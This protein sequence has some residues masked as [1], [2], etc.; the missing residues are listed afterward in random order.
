MQY[1]ISAVHRFFLKSAVD[2]S[3]IREYDM[4][5]C[6]SAIRHVIVLVAFVASPLYSQATKFVI[7]G[8]GSQTAGTTQDLTIRADSAGQPA[9]SYTGVKLLTFSGATSS[10]DPVTAPTVKDTGGVAVAFGTSTPITFVN[11]LAQVSAGKNG[12]MTLYRAEGAL[13]SV[14]DGSISSSGAD[15]LTVTVSSG[16]L[17]KFV[18]SLTSPQSNNAGFTGTNTLTAADDWGNPVTTFSAGSNNVTLTVNTLSGMITGLGSGN[19]NILNR[20]ADFS[21][22]VANLST[23][24]IRYVGTIGSGTITAT[25]ASPS[26]NGTSS[27]ITINPGQAQRLVI[28]GSATQTAGQAQNLTVT[29]RDT[30]GNK[31]TGYSGTKNLLF[32]GASSSPDPVTPPTVANASGTAI[33]FGS[34]T[35]ISFVA[36]EATVS[37]G[38]NGRMRLSK[39][40]TAIIAVTDGTISASGTDRLT[41]TVSPDVAGKF[42]LS[43]AASQTNAV[44]FSGTNTITVLDDYGNTVTTFDASV[45]PVTVSPVGLNGTVIV[46]TGRDSV[47]N[48]VG[49]FS[50]GTANLQGKLTYTGIS[51][52]GQFKVTSSTGKTG[53][54]GTVT[55]SPGTAKRLVLSGS[56]AAAAGAAN[57]LTITAQDTSGNTATGYAGA[58]T[59][60]F[61]GAS[62]SPGGNN[63]TVSDNT[64]TARNFSVTPNTQITFTAGVAS[65]SGASNGVMRLYR[66]ESASVSVT[67]GT[68]ST[69]PA[70]RLGVTITPAGLGS[71]TVVMT[72]PQT[73]GLIFTGVNTVTAIDSFGNVATNFNPASNNVTV[74]T[75]LTGT[76]SGL[77]S[78]GNNVLNQ[79][80]DFSN[81]VANVS[82]KMKYTGSVGTGTFTATSQTGKSGTSGSVVINVGSA[83]R[84]VI[85]GSASQVAGAGQSLTITAKDSSGNTVTAYNGDKMLTFSGSG[86]SPN[87]LTYPTVSSKTGVLVNFGAPTQISFSSGVAQVSA[88]NNGVLRL[89]RAGKDTIAASDGSIGSGTN[90]Q[91]IVTVTA[92]ALAKFVLALTSPQQSGIVFTGTN[93]LTAQDNYGNVKTTFDASVDNVTLSANSPLVGVVS[94]LG[95]LSNNVL[96]QAADFALGVATLTGKLKFT[97]TVGSGTF[98]AVSSTSKAGTSE[99][100]QIVAGG[101][102]RLVITGSA[103]MIAGGT[104]ALVITAKDASGNT[105][106]TYTGSKSLTFS[107]ADSALSPATAPTVTSSTG[108]A[109]P[110][111]AVTAITFTNGVATTSGVNNGSMRLLRAQAAIVSV[112]DGSITSSG[113]DRLSVTVGPATLGKFAWVLATPQ[114]N[115]VAFTGTNTLTAQDDWGNTI[116]AFD[117]SATNVAVAT[118]LS[119][120]VSGLGSGNDNILNRSADFVSGVAN[121]TTLGMKYTG[122][123]GTG[124][125][126]ATGGGKTGISTS[127]LVQSGGATRLVVRNAA[128]DSVTTMVAGGSQN[129][130]I[131]AKD[132]SGNTVVTYTG[133]KS[134]IFSGADSSLKPAVAPTVSN[135]TGTAVGFGGATTITF[136]NGVAQVSGSS[137]GILKLYRAQTAL[138]AV[139]D[140]SLS[141]SGNDRLSV[142]VSPA[143]LGKFAWALTSPQT[144]GVGFTGVNTLQAQDDWGNAV[145][146]FNASTSNVTISTSLSG[147]ITGLGSNNNNV[148]NRV[149]DFTGGV[150]NLTAL[151]MTYTGSI[152]NGTFTATAA[153][154]LGT[155]DSVAIV[156]GSA[157]RLVITGTATQVAG[158]AQNLTITARDGSNN[159]VTTYTG[160]KTLTFSGANPAT[161][162]LTP[163]TMTNDSARAV[164]FGSPTRIL[165][166]NGVASVSGG[167]NGA[168]RLYKAESA[169][170]A[171]TDGTVSS[172][173]VD[174]LSVTVSAGPL[175]QFAWTLASPQVNSVPFTGTN[176][177]SAQDDWGNTVRT[178]DA[179]T[180]NVTVTT[181]LSPSPSAV[182]GLGSLGNNVLNRTADFVQGIANLT[183]LGM[184]YT[185][186]G[187]T[188]T[189]TATS[190]VGSKTGISSTVTMNN[191]VPTLANFAPTEASRRQ[192]LDVAFTGG[193]FL[194]GVTAVDFGPNIKVDTTVVDSASHMTAKITVDSVAALGARNVEVSNPAPGGGAAT[195][196][197]AFTV[198]NIPSIVSLTPSAGVRGQT[199][200]V[201]ITGTNFIPG[202][203]TVYF[204]GSNISL[205]SQAVVSATTIV[206]NITISFVAEDG[207]RQF[208]VTNTGPGGGNSNFKGFTV[209]SNPVPSLA[210]VLPDTASRLE[211][212]GLTF[213]GNNFYNGITSVSMGDGIQVNNFVIDSVSQLR[214]NVTVLDT[215]TV[216]P[217][218][219]VVINASPGG[220]TD[221]LKNGLVVTNPAPTF[222]GLSVQNGARLQTVFL[223]LSGTKF[224]TGVTTVNMGPNIVVNSAIAQSQTQLLI[225]ITIDSSAALGPRAVSVT[226]PPPVGGT[227]LLADAFTVN[228][229]TPTVTTLTPDSTLVGGINLPIVVLGTNFVPGSSVRLGTLPLAS[230]LVNR[231]RLNA[232][233]PASELDTAR[234]FALTVVNL[235]PGGGISN[236]KNFTV[237]NPDP[238]LA[239]VAPASGS[240]LQTLDVVFTGTNYL[241]GVTQVDF[242]GQDVTINGIVVNSST[243]LTANVSISASAAIGPRDVFVVNAPPG[244]GSSEKRTF[245]IAN[246]PV[247]TLATVVP[248]AGD[249]LGRLN[250]VLTGTNFI[251]GVTSANFGAGIVVNQ[252][253]INSPTQLT[254]DILID[255]AAA[256]GPRGVDVTNAAP[257]GGTATKPNAFTV[258]NPLPVLSAITP[259]N[260][261]QLQ[262]L[263]IVLDGRGFIDGVSSVSMGNGVTVNSQTVVSDSQ[264]TANITVTVS[265]ATG[266]R[267]V[268]VTNLPPGG[269]TSVLTNGFVIGN[270]PS[271]RIANVTPDGGRRL[272]RLDVIIRGSNYVSGVTS[273]DFGQNITV[274]TPITVDST[275]RLTANVTILAAATPGVRTIYVRNAPPGG[276]VD[277]LT[278]VFWVVNPVPTLTSLSPATVNRSST[279]NLVVRGTNFLSNATTMNFGTGIFVNSTSVDSATR[280]T[281]NITISDTA[282]IGI[283]NAYASNPTPAGGT[284]GPVAFT[285]QLA[286]P[287][288]PILSTPDN[289]AT[290]LPTT[291]TLRWNASTGAISYHLQ[292]SESSLFLSTLVDD[293]T[294]TTP[295]R[296][297]G[298]LVN[299]K[300]YYWRV[301]ARNGGGASGFSSTW[302]FTPAYP[303][304]FIVSHAES[305]PNYPNPGDFKAT[306]YKIVGL[307]GASTSL[308][309]NFLSGAQGTDWQLYADNGSDVNYLVVFNGTPGFTF[310]AG[311]AYW[312]IRK[313]TWTVNTAV[314]AAPLDT[315]GSVNIQLHRGWNLI[316]NPFQ[317]DIPWTAVQSVNGQAA[318]EP[319]WEYNGGFQ[320]S[321][322]VKT[323]TG[324][325]FF[326][327]DSVAALKIPYG[328]TSGVLKHAESD[329]TDVWAMRVE[330]QS[331][332]MLDRSAVLGVKTDALEGLDRH[333]FHK[334]RAPEGFPSVAFRRHDVDQDFSLFATDFRGGIQKLARWDLEVHTRRNA[335]ATLRLSDVDHVPAGWDV[336]L[337]DVAH[338]RF[339]DVRK[340]AEYEFT[341]SSDIS[342]FV[343]LVGDHDAVAA[344]LQTVVPKEF[345][346]GQNFPNPFNPTTTLPV[347][348]PV[349]SDVS[350]VVYNV[351]G[352]E[353]RTL[354]A[355]MLESGRH[356]IVW[357]GR[358]ES[359]RMVATGTYLARLT[360]PNGGHHLIKLLLM[361]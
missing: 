208:F 114:T 312:L 128:S 164:A 86:P 361:K 102:T 238:T 338:A 302:S 36:G 62:I 193:N 158:T 241:Q 197:N 239:S 111:G 107:G 31:A 121:M 182:T 165:F 118:T 98:T 220:G 192:T 42:T 227:A 272:E 217:R 119:G 155:S 277:S 39:A 97:G 137:N 231:T 358:N 253:V 310:N 246:N 85:T 293:S 105:V 359:G 1:I 256:T 298:P 176:T 120:V 108:A 258:N 185:G 352:Q 61:S 166:T 156:A 16:T 211:T 66:V 106:T 168:M 37:G 68:I 333:D 270:N 325:Y 174:R 257:G 145:I 38:A 226:N 266:A 125:F 279:I 306:D 60:S 10:S 11:G 262:T 143:A 59:L 353:I 282:T 296:R 288:A 153:G 243:K 23:L 206:I 47:L 72:S 54:S 274:N 244:G 360:T 259:T 96:N 4:R 12:V 43:L 191:P 207:V 219:V 299:N 286:A 343:V 152:G 339:M 8:S 278:D 127:V 53:T 305:F 355:G 32:S 321:T 109:I 163:P 65:A 254:A 289:G 209:G 249:R 319:V 80:A 130:V 99:N 79:A 56:S 311:K 237:Q 184:K 178:F 73:N 265:A 40:E 225:G 173:G 45:T 326:N 57:P 267:D 129:L 117:A 264:I 334:P 19:N 183:A 236:V 245:T 320:Q 90:D 64:G 144:S 276:G 58:K 133:T 26:R 27:S 44:A 283:R 200:E 170:I 34:T 22:G 49:D 350:L 268:S 124:T 136:T 7:T 230:T 169:T 180:N 294:L 181:S 9:T 251:N 63:P 92:D 275:T 357:D 234:S 52:S 308:V 330:L 316:T 199:L 151:G 75:G 81:G 340:N 203:S 336:Y 315:S 82:G 190:T 235:A 20:A 318:R 196:L 216:G 210:Q 314:D 140:G 141:A 341:A 112:T 202:V 83:T 29:A 335:A 263:N 213:K 337:V 148:L 87:P 242:G 351:L 186:V 271:P 260:A 69:A 132:G 233:V 51:G 349:T 195:L 14:S 161:N 248:A 218:N 171:T 91:L 115:G 177:L 138:I 347:E 297:V 146:T 281:V 46:G 291:L 301:R 134:L 221:T 287:L 76:V 290:N 149:A 5:K 345:R 328:G 41:V 160:L 331:G 348:L 317:L 71:F 204:L 303:Q 307:P 194:K 224:L 223:T 126:T 48:Q 342:Q 3:I 247:P 201:T 89:Y 252:T 103:T 344:E 157:S 50:S 13:V 162:P 332:D 323:Y 205:N 21:S 304:V 110:F 84:L 198:K 261:Q 189:F 322:T 15:R 35:A 93:T 24:G 175:G 232:S 78:G 30:S 327:A 215:A 292:L 187:G 139:S 309:S 188:G 159:I 154:K 122:V 356:W 17:A 222:T 250:V 300:T 354:H 77:G 74:T 172:S 212:V 113:A 33:S 167:A 329:T 284:S 280:M 55:V 28:T 228:N 6:L 324:Y 147:T 123:V 346:L 88:G 313:N 255:A 131:T 240:R 70:G 18:F 150:A 25:S 95:S 142:T 104:Q 135:S 94:G 100:V 229:P 116:T 67:D 101:A 2:H 179:A 285:V 214:V 295:L 273:V 269:G